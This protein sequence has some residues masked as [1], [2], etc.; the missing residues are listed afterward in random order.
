[1]ERRPIRRLSILLAFLRYT[2]ECSVGA[3]GDTARYRKEIKG[4]QKFFLRA[5]TVAT[6]VLCVAMSFA[7]QPQRCR[8]IRLLPATAPL[9]SP[10]R[11]QRPTLSSG[12][13]RR[14][15][16]DSCPRMV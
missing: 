11:P 9:P 13:A 6:I 2:I 14:W 5:L 8:R 12:S 10:A 3:V 4:V 1:M 15:P 16:P 7:G